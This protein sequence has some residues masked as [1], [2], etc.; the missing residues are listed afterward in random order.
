MGEKVKVVD[1]I[2]NLDDSEYWLIEK[3]DGTQHWLTN[4][5]FDKEIFLVSKSPF[6]I[7]GTFSYDGIDDAPSFE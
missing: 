1:T 5:R 7:E 6:L 4:V 3:E 2:K